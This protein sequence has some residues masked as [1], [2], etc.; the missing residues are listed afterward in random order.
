MARLGM[1]A[2]LVAEGYVNFGYAGVVLY[3]FGVSFAFTWGYLRIAHS[4]YLSPSRLLYYF[5]L[6]STAQL[7]RDGLISGVWFPFVYA[8]PIGWTAVWHWIWKPGRPRVKMPVRP[9]L[10]GTAEYVR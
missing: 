3:C 7:Y 6:A 9:R 5:C 10:E 4:H 8:A 1:T 2:G